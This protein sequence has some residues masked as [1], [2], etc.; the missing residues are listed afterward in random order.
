MNPGVILLQMAIGGL[1]WWFVLGTV[2]KDDHLDYMHVVLA[3]GVAW[4]VGSA[5]EL[6]GGPYMLGFPEIVVLLLRTLAKTFV[7][8]GFLRIEY[9]AWTIRRIRPA[10]LVYFA[11][12]FLFTVPALVRAFAASV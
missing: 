3:Y 10:V 4:A 1:V 5:V 11:T 6:I 2:L 12:E 7:L 8:L 9:S